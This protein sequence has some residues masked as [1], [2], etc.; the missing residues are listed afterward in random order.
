MRFFWET[1]RAE[2]YSSEVSGKSMRRRTVGAAALWTVALLV[3]GCIVPSQEAVLKPGLPP[4]N[5]QNSKQVKTT[6]GGS[7]IHPTI[8]EEPEGTSQAAKTFGNGLLK[9]EGTAQPLS[10]GSDNPFDGKTSR[11]GEKARRDRSATSSK[12]QNQPAKQAWEDQ[13][14]REAAFEKAKAAQ[15]VKKI[16]LCYDVKEHEWW[17]ILYEQDGEFIELEQYIWNDQSQMLQPFLVVKRFPITQLQQRLTEEEPDKPCEILDP[18]SKT[19]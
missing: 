15:G 8:P 4:Q 14:V 2:T 7:L 19:R 5:S 18:P 6:P 11:Q 12:P 1:H 10:S 17:V 3:S 16:K 9:A 13:K